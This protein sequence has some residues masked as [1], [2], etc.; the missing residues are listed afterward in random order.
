M[1]KFLGY[2]WDDSV[3]VVCSR[4]VTVEYQGYLWRKGGGEEVKGSL[5]SRTTTSSVCASEVGARREAFQG[6]AGSEELPSSLMDSVL[7]LSKGRVAL[8]FDLESNLWQWDIQKR[9]YNLRAIRLVAEFADPK[10]LNFYETTLHHPFRTSP[11]TNTGEEEGGLDSHFAPDR[12]GSDGLTFAQTVRDVKAGE[13]LC[14]SYVSVDNAGNNTFLQRQR[15]L[16]ETYHFTCECPRCVAEKAAKAHGVPTREKRAKG[17]KK[18]SKLKTLEDLKSRSSRHSMQ[19]KKGKKNAK[20][21]K[22]RSS[23]A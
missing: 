11:S 7:P 15:E 20:R 6:E 17:R 13:E 14:I 9:K 21:N 3:S 1:T 10:I 5:A 18:A 16:M 12:R 19:K 22:K 2:K 23:R 8:V 4:Q